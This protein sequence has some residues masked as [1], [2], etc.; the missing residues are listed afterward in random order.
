[1]DLQRLFDN[2]SA[3]LPIFVCLEW[4]R[5]FLT[6]FV[7]AQPTT[8]TS[9]GKLSQGKG[10]IIIILVVII[11]MVSITD[12]LDLAP[13]GN[14][15]ASTPKIEIQR[16]N[17]T[18]PLTIKL[19]CTAA[20]N[21]VKSMFLLLLLTQ[22]I[23]FVLI[24]VYVFVFSDLGSSYNSNAV[25]CRDTFGVEIRFHEHFKDVAFLSKNWF[26][27]KNE[28]QIF[29]NPFKVVTN[30]VYHLLLQNYKYQSRMN[31]SKLV[32]IIQHQ[33]WKCGKQQSGVIRRPSDVKTLQ[34][35]YTNFGAGG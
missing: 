7:S 19:E 13:N 32:K 26:I 9:G 34:Q 2:Q 17:N 25:A 35:K 24:V 30:R 29:T 6:P 12:I 23:I 18:E 33:K 14:V 21:L 11:V 10:V 27:I 31:H 20:R 3:Q 16:K 28:A 15:I 5:E 8:T 1:M 22:F 4:S